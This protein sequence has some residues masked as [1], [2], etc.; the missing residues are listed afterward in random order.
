MLLWDYDAKPESAADQLANILFLVPQISVLPEKLSESHRA[1]LCHYL[2]FMDDNR[3]VLL[4][5][6][7]VPL[8][9]QANYAQ[10]YAERDGRV[11]AALYANP[12]F[13][14]PDGTEELTVVNASESDFV[15]L[16]GADKLGGAAYTITDCMGNPTAEGKLSGEGL[17]KL[18]VPHCGFLTI[19]K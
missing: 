16:D 7:L 5:G 4:D 14:V 8:D 10:V 1:M 13:A 2:K 6:N 19:K 15:Y 9:A 12:V 3:D 17:V 11:I 18:S